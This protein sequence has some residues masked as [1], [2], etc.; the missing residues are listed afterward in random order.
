MRFPRV[1][2]EW[3]IGTVIGVLSGYYIFND[4]LKDYAQKNNTKS[5]TITE[6]HKK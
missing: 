3:I 5:I 6:N 4:I 2:E 1:R